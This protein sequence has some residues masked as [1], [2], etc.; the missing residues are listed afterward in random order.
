MSAAG[1]VL[2]GIYK[3]FTLEVQPD[4]L[5]FLII[6]NDGEGR[7]ELLKRVHYGSEWKTKGGENVT[8]E[9]DANDWGNVF[10]AVEGI[11]E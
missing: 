8:E 1:P 6:E 10:A 4:A 3:N 11:T 7:C 5:S 9:W 2:R